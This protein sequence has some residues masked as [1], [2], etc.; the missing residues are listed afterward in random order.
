[1]GQIVQ[2]AVSGAG[3]PGNKNA[4]VAAS[5]AEIAALATVAERATEQ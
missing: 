1:M 3:R 5:T 4:V 2:Q